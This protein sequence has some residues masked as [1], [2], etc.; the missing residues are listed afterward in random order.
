MVLT[1]MRWLRSGTRAF[2]LWRAY[3]VLDHTVA[4]LMRDLDAHGILVILGAAGTGKT[5]LA[6]AVLPG[7]YWVTQD[8]RIDGDADL[9]PVAEYQTLLHQAIESGGKAVVV[10]QRWDDVS[11]RLQGFTPAQYSVVNLNRV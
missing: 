1:M 5:T 8:L 6:E 10:G 4:L 7:G 11:A 2:R 3:F 9:V